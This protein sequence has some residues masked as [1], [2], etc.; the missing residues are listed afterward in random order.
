MA[1]TERIELRLDS[2]LVKRIDNWADETGKASSRSDAIRQ[3]LDIGLGI[4]TGKSIH[5]TDGDKLNFMML[6]EIIKHLEIKS[7]DIN[8]DLIEKSILGGHYWAPTWIASLLFDKDRDT[9][10]E[11]SLVVDTLYM[12][13]LIEKRIKELTPE[14]Q[15]QLKATNNGALPKFDGFDGN[16]ESKLMGIAQFLVHDMERFSYF[17]N[18][19]F[20]SHLQNSEYYRRMTETFKTILPTLANGKTLSVKQIVEILNSGRAK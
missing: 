1:K 11:V 19:E 12:W 17:K 9:P 6:R 5:L 10:E 14:E 3:L 18:R 2:E 8:I 7:P 16:Y 20:N 4:V 15:E 13:E